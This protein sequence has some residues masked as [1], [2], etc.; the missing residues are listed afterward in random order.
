M[1]PKHTTAKITVYSTRWCPDCI[2]AR[3]VLTSAGI[4]YD[5]IDVSKDAQA[6]EI[7]KSMN[8]GNRSVPTI[9]FPDGSLLVE[10]SANELAQKIEEFAS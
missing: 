5:E 10:P 6:A 1:T 8:S 7:V 4:E 9:V 2:R 3:R